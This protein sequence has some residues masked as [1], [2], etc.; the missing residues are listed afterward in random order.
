MIVNK[1][2][3]NASRQW[4]SINCS[5]EYKW[6]EF[7]LIY[8]IQKIHVVSCCLYVAK[9]RSRRKRLHDE[10]VYD[11]LQHQQQQQQQQLL[12]QQQH[13]DVSALVRQA[14]VNGHQDGVYLQ[15]CLVCRRLTL[16][17]HIMRP[18]RHNRPHYGSRQSV[19]PSVQ[20]GLLTR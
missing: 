20:C 15:Q 11:Q 18:G 19:R 1:D 6:A 12:Q 2:F 3:H 5:T 4:N 8:W 10:I 13:H 17:Q 14:A 7:C 16:S 9:I